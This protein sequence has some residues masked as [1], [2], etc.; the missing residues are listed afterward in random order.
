MPVIFAIHR[1]DLVDEMREFILPEQELSLKNGPEDG[2]Y[3]SPTQAQ[4][5]DLLKFFHHRRELL[6][7]TRDAWDCDDMAREFLLL[8]RVWSAREFPGLPLAPI[9]GSV[10]VIVDGP[11]EL[12]P[13]PD[14]RP[15]FG[16]FAHV[17]NCI[18][19][20]DGQ[21]FFFEP[22]SEL[23]IPIDGPLYEGSMEIIKIQI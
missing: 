16:T 7:Y 14:G 6:Q 3:Y 1:T 11:Y 15:A 2:R 8:S 10:Y 12:F 17:L 4:I 5:D 9:V 18:R 22:Q 19:R 13:R 23:M 21:W 20:D